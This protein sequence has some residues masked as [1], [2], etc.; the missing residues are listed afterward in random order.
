MKKLR[1]A[2]RTEEPAPDNVRPVDLDAWTR[3]LVQLAMEAEGIT[4]VAPPPVVRL[5]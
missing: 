5:G 3:R 1:L 4:D 2:V